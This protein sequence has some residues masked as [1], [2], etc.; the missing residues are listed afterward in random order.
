MTVNSQNPSK[1]DHAQNPYVS[2]MEKTGR[3]TG[4]LKFEYQTLHT[5]YSLYF[6]AILIIVSVSIVIASYIIANLDSMEIDN[7]SMYLCMG[8]SSFGCIIGVSFCLYDTWW[9][10]KLVEPISEK[11]SI[12]SESKR[13]AE[14]RQ[15]DYFRSLYISVMQ[16]GYEKNMAAKAFLLCAFL[17]A[18]SFISLIIGSVVKIQ[19]FWIVIA[20]YA[21]LIIKT[22]LD[23]ITLKKYSKFITRH[24]ILFVDAVKN[25]F[26]EEGFKD[27]RETIE[28]TL[29]ITRK[30]KT[31]KFIIDFFMK[32]ID[33]YKTREEKKKAK[34][35]SKHR[36]GRN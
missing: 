16:M 3:T 12:Y 8:S 27:L 17:F 28:F 14:K 13:T 20:C 25:I 21:C 18:V 29:L 5:Q 11:Y 23:K 32:E 26:Y 36:H 30:R 22:V 24:S 34:K 35:A 4:D 19:P 1:K 2:R 9:K 33:K 6:N 7:G 15:F 31:S 10:N